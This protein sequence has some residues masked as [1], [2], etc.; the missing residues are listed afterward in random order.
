[1]ANK[2]LRTLI[3]TALLA[4]AAIAPAIAQSDEQRVVA[5]TQ[6]VE[7]PALDA[8]YQGVRDE[9]EA[10]GYNDGEQVRIMHESAQG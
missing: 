1:M 10:Q 6:I 4:M 8:V 9:L 7:H 2:I 5:I 3:G